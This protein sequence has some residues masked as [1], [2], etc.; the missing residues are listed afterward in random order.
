MKVLFIV[1]S[2][3][4]LALA[5]CSTPKA[6]VTKKEAG[7]QTLT[8]EEKIV[9]T[10]HMDYHERTEFYYMLQYDK[11]NLYLTLA[12]F[13]QNLQR[14]IG[15]FGFTV[16]IDKTGGKNR[17]Q[18]FRFPLG[19]RM[20]GDY[21]ERSINLSMM[22][23]RI[24]PINALLERADEIDLIGI[25]GTSTRT[26]RMRDSRIRVKAERI[27]NMLIYEAVIPY[28]LLRFGFNPLADI[29]SM[30]IGLE[31]GHF[32]PTSTSGGRTP[33]D[34]RRPGGMSGRVPGRMPD[35]GLMNQRL[36]NMG[37]LSRPTRLWLE[38][39]FDL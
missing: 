12:T 9:L 36:E 1:V 31:T 6:I 8:A 32:E 38:L 21:R 25:Y 22:G 3:S 19:A 24:G 18:G 4:V 5:G 37:E 39:E 17:E 16:W 14:K 7:K 28:E 2:L 29:I 15:H 26:V 20:A 35:R 10:E 33:S 30:S 11:S 13:N 27:E 23:Y 34:V